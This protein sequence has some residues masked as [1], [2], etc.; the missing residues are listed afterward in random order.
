[1]KLRL[2]S[3][4]SF[5]ALALTLIVSLGVDTRQSVAAPVGSSSELTYL[6]VVMNPPDLY[7][8]KLEISQSVQDANNSVPL[9]A[10]RP[11]VVRVYTETKS[12][13]DGPNTTVTLMAVRGGTPLT[14]VTSNSKVASGSSSR[15]NLGSTY[16]VTLPNDWLSGTVQIT[17]VIDGQ[18][19]GGYSETITFNNVPT[20]NVMVVPINYTQTGASGGNGFYAAPGSEQ[21][22]D[23]IMRAYPLSDM[24][25]TFRSAYSFTGNLRDSGSEWSRLLEEVTDLKG[26][27]NAPHSTVYY[28]YI[29]FGT[30][31][32]NTWFNC[33]G[34]IAGIGWIGI[35]GS[36][37]DPRISVGIHNLPSGFGDDASGK[38]AG[39]EIGHN[40]GRYHAPCNVTGTNW[41][42]DPKHAGASIGEYGLDGIG[43]T[44][45]L[46]SPGGYVDMMSYCDPVWVSD[47]TYE[48]LYTDQV[49]NGAFIWTPQN[50][51]LLISGS[52][53]E[54]GSVSLNPVYFVPATAVSPQNGLYQVELLDAVGNVIATHP[55]DLMVAEEEGVSANAMRGVVPAPDV[56][57]AELRVI[58]VATGTAV[59][60]RTLSTSSLAVNATL[61]QRSDTATVSWGVA[62]VPAN[63]RYTVDNG[64]T[65]TTVGLNVLGGTLEVDLTNLPG[66]GNGRFQ[67]ILADQSIPTRFEV[68]LATPL[69]DKQPTAWISGPE[70]VSAGAPAA[71]YALGSDA[72]DGALSD[73]VWSVDGE[74]VEADSALFLHDL[75]PGEHVITLRATTSSGQTAVAS[76]IVTVT[77]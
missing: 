55:V 45:A 46:Y 21:I 12:G 11:T 57:V 4:L 3:I 62:D 47:F 72:E 36:S 31:C 41:S 38:L 34:G 29:N 30:S 9:V 2:A 48:A 39:H 61:A 18:S 58:E 8:T 71:L 42:T 77:P 69:S 56:P 51:S 53:A 50:E 20:L 35:P 14:P 70:V 23:W 73:F 17:A 10:N 15:A 44:L 60:N 5:M 63:V 74:P 27:D 6:P 59:A 33:S 67:I 16:N 22:S 54:D 65:W 1:M 40:F 75:A 26:T 66:G 37:F 76:H 13:D 28:A 68:D 43:G 24:N 52:V 64:L 19:G 32:S 49:N 7:I 25:V